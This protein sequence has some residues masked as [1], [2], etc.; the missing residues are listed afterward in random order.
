MATELDLNNLTPQQ[1]ADIVWA[2]N[3][4]PKWGVTG[5]ADGTTENYY[6]PSNTNGGND[7]LISLWEDA[8]PAERQ[9]MAGYALSHPG[10]ANQYTIQGIEPLVDDPAS[11]AGSVNYQVNTG[12]AYQASGQAGAGAGGAGQRVPNTIDVSN[13]QLSPQAQADIGIIRNMAGEVYGRDPSRYNVDPNAIPMTQAY[14]YDPST[15]DI[16]TSDISNV[17]DPTRAQY[18]YA[19]DMLNYASDLQGTDLQSAAELQYLAATGQEPSAA[20][21]AL[22]RDA[23]ALFAQQMA[24]AARARGSSSS[25]LATMN[26][27]NNSALG[28]AQLINNA[29]I[30]RANEMAT[31]RGQYGQTGLGIR[32]QD[33]GIAGQASTNA[34]GL[35]AVNNSEL[36]GM[37][38]NT[39]LMNSGAQFNTGQQ[40]NAYQYGAGAMQDASGRNQDATIGVLTGNSNRAAGVG[41]AD[42]SLGA[43]YANTLI[44]AGQYDT[45]TRIRGGQDFQSTEENIQSIA[46]NYAVGQGS[47]TTQ[48]SIADDNRKAQQEAAVI[49]AVGTAATGIAN[50]VNWE[51]PNSDER[52]K[53]VGRKTSPADFSSVEPHEWE[54]EDEYEGEPGTNWTGGGKMQSGM[55]QD[56]P[57]SVVEKDKD[58][59]LRVNPLKA[60]M[61]YADSI[62][63]LQR[64]VKKMEAR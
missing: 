10:F 15:A 21:L 24:M 59:M 43:N 14:T 56:F 47:N 19:N 33:I 44:G 11:P 36:G 55:A 58:G 46:N 54:Y 1:K 18:G 8:T 62:G 41:Q 12:T 52:M 32:Q 37:Q 64:R 17:F 20:D 29:D 7:K 2:Y 49:G 61:R 25:G 26:A 28:Y 3:Q 5:H 6:G 27:Q 60:M 39:R 57:D 34:Q 16:Y 53:N 63:D 4:Q 22:N 48:R 42:D 45:D 23:N 40:N 50:A 31:A 13:Y 38:E 51:K 30:A 35:Y 9:A